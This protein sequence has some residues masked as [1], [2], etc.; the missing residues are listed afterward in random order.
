VRETGDSLPIRW[1]SL[2]V[3]PVLAGGL[4]FSIEVTFATETVGDKFRQALATVDARCKRER[5]GPYLEKEDPD[6]QRK[7]ADTSCDILKLR[8]RDWD[9]RKFL[10][11][12]AQPYSVPDDWVST[13]EGKFAHSI[14][15]PPPYD[16][17][18][19]VYKKGMSAADYF[20]ALCEEE[21][22]DFV[23]RRVKAVEV[24]F[25]LRPRNELPPARLLHL[26][27]IEDPYGYVRGET[28]SQIPTTW[29]GGNAYRALERKTSD[30]LGYERVFRTSISDRK[31]SVE[32]IDGPTAEYGFTWR[33]ITRPHDRENG[34][35]GGELIA[36]DMHTNEVLGFRRGFAAT[37]ASERGVSWEFAAVC[38]KQDFRRGRS[39]D[40]DFGLW[41]LSEV[42]QPPKYAQYRREISGR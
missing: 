1:T 28:R 2:I 42:L 20:R 37:D 16:K 12:D 35:A 32:K 4:Y 8:P 14:R 34:I 24:V 11:V 31:A 5:R 18:R 36:V 19:Q 25:D 15:L 40:F 7:V 27:S 29:T 3:G 33:G 38:P 21:A 41:F 9:E 22:G 6:F 17:P 39:K 26:F 23:I 13:A 30:G 10:K